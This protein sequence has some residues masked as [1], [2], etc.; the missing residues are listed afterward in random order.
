LTAVR[1]RAYN[2][3]ADSPEDRQGETRHERE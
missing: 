1:A 2:P 3:P